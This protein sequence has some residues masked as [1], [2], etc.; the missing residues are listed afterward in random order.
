MANILNTANY[1]G[2]SKGE[3]KQTE[4]FNNASEKN[5][6]LYANIKGFLVC[7]ACK[8][9]TGNLFCYARSN[10]ATLT[11]LKDSTTIYPN[12]ARIGSSVYLIDG[13]AGDVVTIYG[14]N[15]KSAASGNQGCGF[16]AYFIE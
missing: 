4:I 8:E 7:S 14:T 9:N 2:G 16:I 6:P 1:S 13:K 11:L 5:I 3:I 15:T 12:S 10:D